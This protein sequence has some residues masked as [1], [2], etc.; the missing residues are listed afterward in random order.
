MKK[1][2]TLCFLLLVNI[3]FSSAQYY[4]MSPLGGSLA[5]RMASLYFENKGIMPQVV[6]G[7]TVPHYPVYDTSN[8]EDLENETNGLRQTI[9]TQLVECAVLDMTHTLVSVM[10]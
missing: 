4:K 6:L 1:F 7:D 2:L 10:I 9:R 5:Y 3:G 8:S